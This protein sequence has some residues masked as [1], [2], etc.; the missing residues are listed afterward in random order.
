MQCIKMHMNLM[1]PALADLRAQ[2]PDIPEPS[3]NEYLARRV[4]GPD[5]TAER[6]IIELDTCQQRVCRTY[7]RYFLAGAQKTVEKDS[8]HGKVKFKTNQGTERG[9]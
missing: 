5:S 4:L 8:F 9:R 1:K 7:T 2:C 6:L 3:L